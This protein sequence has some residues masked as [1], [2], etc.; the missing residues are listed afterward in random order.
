MA[1]PDLT[2]TR[3][4][5]TEGSG[6]VLVVGP[7]LGTSVEALWEATAALLGEQAEILGWDLPGHGRSRPADQPFTVSE[8]AAAVR[9]TAADLVGGGRQAVY[10]GVSLGGAVALELALDPG[11][12]AEVACVASAPRIG[13][14]EV[15]RERADLVRSAGT[16][17][18]VAG[19]A[20][21][22][23]AP[24]F[25]DRAPTVASRLL[26]SLS[27][28][29]D[30]SYALAC[31]ALGSFDLRERLHQARVPVLVVPGEYDVVVPP[32]AA[33]EAAAA[34][35]AARLVV[36]DGCGHLPPAEAPAAVADLFATHLM[37][38]ARG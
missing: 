6:P 17:V 7:S 14:P 9:R 34:I 20:E 31:D 29:D 3:L 18:L 24:G 25:V 13:G 36:A 22:W 5:G 33:R 35:P 16:P 37:E 12:F 38:A 26:H 8:L 4:A 23:F 28:A 15:W 19:A 21:R 2:F 32:A 30:E 11:P 27:D 1:E 10:A